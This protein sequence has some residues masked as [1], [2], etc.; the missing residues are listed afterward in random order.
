MTADWRDPVEIS[1]SSASHAA[2]SWLVLRFAPVNAEVRFLAGG[3]T[4]RSALGR[5]GASEGTGHGPA[6]ETEFTIRL[7]RT[8]GP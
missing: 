4:A 2:L 1:D 7:S 3:R 5:R 8:F 6:R